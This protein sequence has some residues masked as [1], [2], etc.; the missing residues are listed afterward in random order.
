MEIDY[1]NYYVFQYTDTQVKRKYSQAILDKYYKQV[2]YLYQNGFVIPTMTEEEFEEQMFINNYFKDTSDLESI[3]ELLKEE[4]DYSLTPMG[5]KIIS[6][7]CYAILKNSQF[8][9]LE[10]ENTEIIKIYA[11]TNWEKIKSNTER[12]GKLL[13]S[14]DEQI[15]LSFRNKVDNY[16]DLIDKQKRLSDKIEKKLLV[17][18][19]LMFQDLV[20][21]IYVIYI[22]LSKVKT[23]SSRSSTYTSIRDELY[24]TQGGYNPNTNEIKFTMGSALQEIKTVKTTTDKNVLISTAKKIAKEN[25][26][27]MRGEADYLVKAAKGY[28]VD[29]EQVRKVLI[30]VFLTGCMNLLVLKYNLSLL[31]DKTNYIRADAIEREFNCILKTLNIQRGDLCLKL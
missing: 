24:G 2:C 7:E 12:F 15:V 30:Q 17:P 1:E 14:T 31:D 5:D 28:K 18:S 6:E 13:T 16:S 3:K 19:W 23:D 26:Y 11:R 9:T 21:H 29:P 27:D 8:S 10:C 25:K 20:K 4:I 22:K